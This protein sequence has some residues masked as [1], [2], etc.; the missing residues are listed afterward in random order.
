MHSDKK[1][2]AEI[3][4]EHEEQDVIEASVPPLMA[5]HFHLKNSDP[6]LITQDFAI[7]W[8]TKPTYGGYAIYE[9]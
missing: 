1:C 9:S 2:M 6:G 8:I 7:S 3:V 5:G 4:A